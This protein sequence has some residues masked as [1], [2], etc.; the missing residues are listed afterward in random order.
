MLLRHSQRKELLKQTKLVENSESQIK[1]LRVVVQ[2]L[3]SRKSAVTQRQ[4]LVDLHC[5]LHMFLPRL[6][7][8][9]LQF[10]NTIAV[11]LPPSIF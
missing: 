5:A 8:T 11:Q 1:R 4:V 9:S 2:D 6:H 10:F 3:E 7:P